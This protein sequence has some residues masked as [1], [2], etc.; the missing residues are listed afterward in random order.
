[1][2]VRTFL[3]LK[4]A[5]LISLLCFSCNDEV[6]GDCVSREVAFVNE[7]EA[8]ETSKVNEVVPVNVSFY[9][10]N[11]CGSFSEFRESSTEEGKI[12]EVMASYIGCICGQAIIEGTQT[13][14]F[15]PQ[16]TGV[17]QLNFR[18]SA[19]ELITIYIEV[20]E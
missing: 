10:K 12:I 15:I 18:S 2:K 16:S 11:T 3:N 13:Y 20:T 6:E 7:V 17:Y 5:I 19:T 14:E 9:M 4:L 8:P 1:M